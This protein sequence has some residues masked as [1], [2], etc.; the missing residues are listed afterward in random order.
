MVDIVISISLCDDSQTD[1][2]GPCLTGLRLIR[3]ALKKTVNSNTSTFTFVGECSGCFSL[4]YT[5]WS[6][7]ITSQLRELAVL[8]TERCTVHW[9]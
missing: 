6:F 1:L 2:Q 3:V 7:Q 9:L 4:K 8:L 5:S